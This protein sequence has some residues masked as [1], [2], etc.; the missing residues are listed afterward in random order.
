MCGNKNRINFLW[1]CVCGC[2]YIQM[3][4]LEVHQTEYGGHLWKGN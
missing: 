4:L 2:L 3:V 1:M